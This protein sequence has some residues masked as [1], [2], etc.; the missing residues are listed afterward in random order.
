MGSLEEEVKSASA[1]RA[2]DAKSDRTKARDKF[3]ILYAE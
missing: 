2:L 1:A 3:P